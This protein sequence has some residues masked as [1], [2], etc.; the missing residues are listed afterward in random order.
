MRKQECAFLLPLWRWR[1]FSLGCGSQI[2][3]LKARN[4]LNKGVASFGRANYA[5]AVEHF[6]E[7]IRR[8]SEFA[9]TP[10]ST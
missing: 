5:F 9:P 1:L 3:Y 2:S 8:R 10:A 6:K 7:A 4:A